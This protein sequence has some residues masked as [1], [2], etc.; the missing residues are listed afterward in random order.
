EEQKPSFFELLY[1]P[2]KGAELMNKMHLIAQK[3]R[4]YAFQN[5]AKTNFL[6]TQVKSYYDSLQMITQKYNDLLGGKWNHVMSMVQGVTASYFEMPNID[7]IDIP[8]KG[9]ME[10]FVQNSSPVL[11]VKNNFTLPAFN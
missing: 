8:E 10:L 7:S 11:G 3:N 5:R 4:W 2:V 6:G 1:Y 9:G